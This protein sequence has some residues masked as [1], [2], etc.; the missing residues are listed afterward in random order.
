MP[1]CTRNHR[2]LPVFAQLPE[3]QAGQGRHKCAACAYEQGYDQGF[4]HSA[5]NFDATVL[6]DSQAGIVRHKDCESAYNLG[7]YHGLEAKMAQP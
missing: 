2:Y 5:P 4:A 3:S 6:D 1:T 7:F